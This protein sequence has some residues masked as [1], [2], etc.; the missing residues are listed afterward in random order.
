MSRVVARLTVT[1]TG[2]LPSLLFI[3]FRV[4]TLLHLKAVADWNP[5]RLERVLNTLLQRRLP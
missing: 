2:A 1:G 5:D 3:R 4:C